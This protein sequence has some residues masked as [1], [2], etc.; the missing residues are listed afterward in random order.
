MNRFPPS[1]I[2]L[3]CSALLPILVLSGCA[4]QIDRPP[5]DEELKAQIEE[6]VRRLTGDGFRSLTIQDFKRLE[7]SDQYVAEIGRSVVTYPV[8]FRAHIETSN[9]EID[10]VDPDA[11]YYWDHGKL[12]LLNTAPATPSK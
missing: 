6:N 1:T 8:S 5:T 2:G 10:N 9:G 7:P 4:K 11:R 3:A 12:K